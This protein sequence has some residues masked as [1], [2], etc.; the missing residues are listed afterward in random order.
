MWKRLA[1]SE[2]SIR[3]SVKE[4]PPTTLLTAQNLQR[5]SKEDAFTTLQIATTYFSGTFV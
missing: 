5:I 3:Q 2:M 4:V 1:A